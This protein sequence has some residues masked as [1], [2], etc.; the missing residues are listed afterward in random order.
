MTT[1][2]VVKIAVN[3]HIIFDLVYVTMSCISVSV[4][5]MVEVADFYV[6][7]RYKSQ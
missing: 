3:I 2:Y 4:C 7:A 6:L 1:I 5:A